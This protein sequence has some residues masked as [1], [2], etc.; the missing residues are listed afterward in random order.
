MHCVLCGDTGVIKMPPQCNGLQP[1][2]S[3]GGLRRRATV[4]PIYACPK[5]AIG[6]AENAVAKRPY[7][8]PLD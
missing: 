8:Q 7:L 2:G 5:C 3:I 6:Q 4:G 1:A